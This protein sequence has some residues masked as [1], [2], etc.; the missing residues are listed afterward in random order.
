I[1]KYFNFE[2]SAFDRQDKADKIEHVLLKVNEFQDVKP[3]ELIFVDD[4][5]VYLKAVNDRFP[6]VKCIWA[7]YRMPP[8][9]KMLNIDAKEMY[10]IELW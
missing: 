9:L 5:F 4:N 7:H 10:G 3:S 6:D 2:I 1:E 8:G